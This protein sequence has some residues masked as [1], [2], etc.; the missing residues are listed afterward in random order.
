MLIEL[1]SNGKPF[2]IAISAIVVC[3]AYEEKGMP[4]KAII[5]SI[6]NNDHHV[7]Q[8]YDQIRKIFGDFRSIE[9]LPIGG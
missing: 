9:R 4:Y 5:R 6:N 8:S 3:E 7:D 1:T 2:L